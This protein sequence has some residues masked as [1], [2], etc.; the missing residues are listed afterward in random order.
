[1]SVFP[2][3]QDMVEN[4]PV[5]PAVIIT[6]DA[7]IGA[8]ELALALAH[9]FCGSGGKS[10]NPDLLITLP[11]NN[12]I[13][14]VAIRHLIEFLSL[15]PVNRQRRVAVVLCADCMHSSAANALLKTL[16]E[17]LVDKALVL[18]TQSLQR[19]PATI[20]SRCRVYSAPLP[21]A[22][23]AEEAAQAAAGL[24]PF[25]SYRPLAAITYPS[26]WQQLLAGIFRQG[27]AIDVNAAISALNVSHEGGQHWQQVMEKYLNVGAHLNP[28][29][30]EWAEKTGDKHRWLDGL[31][32]WVADGVRVACALPPLF[33]PAHA[34]VLQ[35]FTAGK[36]RRWLDFYRY[37]LERRALVAH[38]LV[39]DL[40]IREIL[41]AYRRLC[42]D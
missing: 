35:K 5:A 1:M 26:D 9:N 32:K 30:L 2:W 38:P 41:Y 16:E 18:W 14:V 39:K 4:T 28:H 42:A 10:T 24:L 33:F 20:I 25:C 37:L 8:G 13:S 40:F 22:G 12:N 15:A 29:C 11:E 31:Q 6:G 3:Q 19:L 36:K 23:E 21:S 34:T 7:G 27:A 17:P